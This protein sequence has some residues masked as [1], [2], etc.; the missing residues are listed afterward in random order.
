[1]EYLG[2]MYLNFLLLYQAHVEAESNSTSLWDMNNW[3]AQFVG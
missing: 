1:M 3:H 2:D